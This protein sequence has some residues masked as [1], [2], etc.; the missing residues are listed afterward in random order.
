MAATDETRLIVSLEASVTKFERAMA[1]ANGT[2]NSRARAIEKRFAQM[3]PNISASFTR[4]GAVVGGAFTL[5]AAQQ[6]IDA[7]T[8]IN[9]ALKVAGLSGDELTRVYDRLAAS[10]QENAAPIEALVQLYSRAS[11]VQKE[12]GISTEEL[13]R[14]TDEVAIALRVSGRSAAESSGALLQLSQALGSGIVRAEE[15]NSILEGA[16]PIAQAAAAGLEEAGGS[17]AKLRQLVVDGKVSSEAFFRAF[18]AGRPILEEK[19]AGAVITLDGK[20]TTLWNTAIRAT[21]EIDKATGVSAALGA[22]LDGA[23]KQV[24]NTGNMFTK[25]AR[26]IALAWDTISNAVTFNITEMRKSFNLLNQTLFDANL[27]GMPRNFAAGMQRAQEAV[28][29]GAKNVKPVSL[30]DYA[31]PKT[32]S[33]GTDKK[34]DIERETERMRKQTA[35]LQAET[36]A[37]ARLNPLMADYDAQ[38]EKAVLLQRLLNAAQEDGVKITPELKAKFETLAGS[39]ATASAEAQKLADSQEQIR[40]NAEEMRDLGRDMMSGFISDLRHGTTAAEA[41]ANALNKVADKLFDVALDNIFG[42]RGN[43]GILGGAGGG[44]LGG[45]IIPGILHDGGVAGRDGYRHGRAVSPSTFAGAPRYHTGGIAGLKPNE[46]PAILQKG[47]IVIPKV[48]SAARAPAAGAADAVSVNMPVTINVAQGT[49][50]GIEKL[51][52]EILPLMQKVAEATLTNAF[53]RK[54]RFAKSGL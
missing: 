45:A 41:L 31:A 42:A 52:G 37:R 11:L 14:F 8:R 4:L 30:A 26:Q 36:A 33:Q 20:L 2:A 27:I 46:V 32:K 19:V 17:V 53:N 3:N 47:E 43:P 7:S 28:A 34:T 13:L 38:V 6:M 15:F 25:S 29:A 39:Y 16:L 21:A 40:A 51:R 22:V 1:K 23:S 9:N 10:A 12:L 18:E 5:R 35:L 44:L 50:E 48:G 24:E 54:N 49:P